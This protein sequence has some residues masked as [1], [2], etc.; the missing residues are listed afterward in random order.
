MNGLQVPIVREDCRETE[1]QKTKSIEE[2]K[3]TS[4][5]GQKEERG[6][7][8]VSPT[9]TT[10]YRAIAAR[11]NFL[12]TDRPDILYAAKALTR[13]MAEPTYDDWE[14]SVR[15]G[16]YL[17][18]RPKLSIWYK[19][20][21]LPIQMETFSDTDWAGCKRT[22]RSTTGG[23]AV[24][25]SHLIKTWCKTQAVIALSSAEAELYGIVR[26]SAETLGLI[27]MYKDMGESIE[28]TVLGDASATVANIQRRGLGKLRHLDTSYLWVQEVA[29]R[30]Q[31]DDQKV[32]GK[33]KRGRP[34]H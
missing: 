7:I 10:K 3:K 9:E 23:Y 18:T 11:A 5:L 17:K 27:S 1:E 26:A 30:K 2:M 8:K 21:E 6:G 14:K 19:Y 13:K 4:K 32:H 31:L 15:P 24:Y 20:Q 34:F 29:A 16:R 25:G 12:A 28:R 22:R 33:G